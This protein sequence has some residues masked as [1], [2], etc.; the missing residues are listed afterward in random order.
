MAVLGLLGVDRGPFYNRPGDV[1]GF[2][3]LFEATGMDGDALCRVYLSSKEFF[4]ETLS[5]GSVPGTDHS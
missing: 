3:I 1:G 2:S 5:V 4:F